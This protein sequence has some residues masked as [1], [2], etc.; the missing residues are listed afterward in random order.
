MFCMKFRDMTSACSGVLFSS[1]HINDCV[2]R[3]KILDYIDRTPIHPERKE[4]ELPDL[5]QSAVDDGQMFGI[6]KICKKYANINSEEDLTR[7]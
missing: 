4:K 5:I 1:K 7:L 6:F 2:F 3:S